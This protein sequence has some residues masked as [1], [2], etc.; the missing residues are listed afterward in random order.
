MDSL[1]TA[2]DD[3]PLV[4]RAKTSYRAGMTAVA[5]RYCARWIRI[6]GRWCGGEGSV[7]C[8]YKRLGQ[9]EAPKCLKGRNSG[10]RVIIEPVR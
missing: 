2:A 4:A 8:R 3:A 10:F 1:T 6:A 7:P 5:Q 9:N